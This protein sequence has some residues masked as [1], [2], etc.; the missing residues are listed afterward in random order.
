MYIKTCLQGSAWRDITN[1]SCDVQTL[2]LSTGPPQNP[3][4]MSVCGGKVPCSLCRYGAFKEYYVDPCPL[5]V[6]GGTRAGGGEIPRCSP[7]DLEVFR[8]NFTSG[9]SQLFPVAGGAQGLSVHLSAR[10]GHAPTIF[11]FT[12]GPRENVS[13]LLDSLR[14]FEAIWEPWVTYMHISIDCSASPTLT[15]KKMENVQR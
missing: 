14:K 11:S 1:R 12:Y 3:E 8:G 4:S 5:F 13:K 15:N 6:W 9:S 7:H 2:L 10:S